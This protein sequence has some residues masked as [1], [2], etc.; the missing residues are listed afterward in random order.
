MPIATSTSALRRLLLARSLRRAAS[1]S[2]SRA[3]RRDMYSVINV[4]ATRMT[5]PASAVTPISQWK[6]KQIT[7]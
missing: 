6:A 2:A 4:N 7:R 1:V 3:G 5:A